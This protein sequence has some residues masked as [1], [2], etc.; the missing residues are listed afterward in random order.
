MISDSD[1]STFLKR[2]IDKLASK[3]R[4]L[5]LIMSKTEKPLER[6]STQTQQSGK[7]LFAYAAER[8]GVDER[9]EGKQSESAGIKI[10]TQTHFYFQLKT[11]P[12]NAD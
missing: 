4:G 1:S 3:H 5:K 9:G 8:G 12:G 2:F 11:I 6:S 7:L 10:F